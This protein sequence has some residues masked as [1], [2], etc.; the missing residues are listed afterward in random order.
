MDD[1][2]DHIHHAMRSEA[3]VDSDSLADVF[4]DPK[5]ARILASIPQALPF[6]R[7]VKLFDSLL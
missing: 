5:M 6:H 7:R 1:E 4:S 3:D 2:D